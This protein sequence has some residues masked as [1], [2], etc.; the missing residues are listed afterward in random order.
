MSLCLPAEF[1]RGRDL[2]KNKAQ[3]HKRSVQ[4]YVGEREEGYS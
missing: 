1:G 2:G 4:G 3:E